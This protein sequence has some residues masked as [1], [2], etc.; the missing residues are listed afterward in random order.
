[1]HEEETLGKI[2]MMLSLYPFSSALSLAA[3]IFCNGCLSS[4]VR[5]LAL[6]ASHLAPS[7]PHPD[8]LQTINLFNKDSLSM[9]E[10]MLYFIRTFMRLKTVSSKKKLA[11]PILSNCNFSFIS[12]KDYSISFDKERGSKGI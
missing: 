5:G 9:K 12:L 8:A 7:T 2:R 11:Y 4:L 3:I 10:G 1:M 6:Y